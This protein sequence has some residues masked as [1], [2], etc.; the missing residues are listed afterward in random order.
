MTNGNDILEWEENNACWL[1]KAYADKF[2]VFN[3]QE[4]WDWVEEQYSERGV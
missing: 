3:T 2:S 4:Y 1:E